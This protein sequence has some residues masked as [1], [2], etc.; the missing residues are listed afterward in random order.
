MDVLF[1]LR[2]PHA[3]PRKHPRPRRI[4][5]EGPDLWLDEEIREAACDALTVMLTRGMV[6]A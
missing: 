3:L 5:D 2:N 1:K 6:L 4:H